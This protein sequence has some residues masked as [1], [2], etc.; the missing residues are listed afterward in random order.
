MIHDSRAANIASTAGWL[1]VFATVFAFLFQH[2]GSVA[3]FAAMSGSFTLLL[4]A[5]VIEWYFDGGRLP[6]DIDSVAFLLGLVVASASTVVYNVEL[7]IPQSQS[8]FAFFVTV[9]L[10]IYGGGGLVLRRVFFPE[11]TGAENGGES[12]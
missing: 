1:G 5:H 7:W 10:V 8:A 9:P 3:F 12:A 4:W 11:S 6:E 2:I